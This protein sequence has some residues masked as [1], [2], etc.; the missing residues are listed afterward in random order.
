M[1]KTPYPFQEEAIELGLERN[2]LLNDECGLGKKLTM[3]EVAR[4][5]RATLHLPTLVVTVKRDTLQWKRE[6]LEQDPTIPVVV[7]IS[8]GPLWVPEVPDWWL[9]LH[10]EALVRHIKGLARVKFGTVILDEGHHIK[11]WQAQRTKAAKKLRAQRKLVGTGTPMDRTPADLWSQLE[12]LYPEVYRGTRRAFCNTH[13]RWFIDTAGYR[14]TLPGVKS[15][16][17]LSATLAPFTLNRTKLDVA[18]QLPPNIEKTVVIEL[19]GPQA[20]LY[21]RIQHAQDI[22]VTDESLQD[23]IMVGTA[24]AQMVREQQA[25]LDP[26]LLGS[27]AESAKL[28]WLRDWREANPDERTLIFTNYR[29]VAEKLARTYDAH[30]IMGGVPLPEHWTKP[31]VVATIKAAGEALD[32]GTYTTTIFLDG[33]HSQLRMTQAINRTDRLNKVGPT[34]TIYLIAH[35]TVDELIQASWH[36]KWDRYTLLRRYIDWRHGASHPLATE[37]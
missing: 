29:H 3:L 9:I 22:I 37:R 36:D 21:R 33:N 2:L 17:A 4:R 7:G 12:F 13:E 32:L 30:L 34:E 14:R 5:R 24:L 35:N 23:P 18:P 8:M 15:S 6:I 16:T 31:T 25:A 10:Y 26:T 27:T 28:E 11:S 19:T 1:A 20:T